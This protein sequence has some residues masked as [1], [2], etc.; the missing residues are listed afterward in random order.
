MTKQLNDKDVSLDEYEK[1]V[2]TLNNTYEKE[3][4]KLKEELKESKEY[5]D[6]DKKDKN[7]V[8]KKISELIEEKQK[9]IKEKQTI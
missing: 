5:I 1:K 2:I 8:L 9:Y 3:I 7:M 6:S 4:Q